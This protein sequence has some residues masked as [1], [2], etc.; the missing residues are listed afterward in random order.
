MTVTSEKLTMQ[1]YDFDLGIVDF[2]YSDLF[3]AEKLQK[4]TEKFFDD[5][6]GKDPLVH[7]V[8]SK[9][10]AAHG[11]GYEKRVES[12][13]LTD[14]AP[15]LSDFVG[16]LFGISSER[17]ELEHSIVRLDPI[18]RYKF[19]VQRRAAKKFSAEAVKELDGNKLD[20]AITQLRNKAFDET[21][22]EDDELGYA[23]IASRLLDAEE[24]LKAEGDMPIDVTDT[25][26]KLNSAYYKLKDDV[27]GQFFAENV[28]SSDKTGEALQVDAA[29]TM[30]EAW[31][32]KEFYAKN[33]QVEGIQGAARSRLSESCPSYSP[34][35][36]HT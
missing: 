14:A 1:Q 26:L 30:L 22:V 8:L 32:A 10:I 24:A 9:Y 34:G 11:L 23:Q 18:W 2:K 7:D 5:L 25:L 17:S 16:R 20:L 21:L 6:K 3:D 19:F 31:S 28:V 35:R 33:T 13:I 29:L 15:Y 4:L 36:R 27:Y 12:K